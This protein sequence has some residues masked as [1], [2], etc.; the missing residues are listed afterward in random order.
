MGLRDLFKPKWEHSDAKVRAAAVATLEDTSTVAK[1]AQFDED[2]D[3]R[4]AAVGRLDDQPT[5]ETVATSDAERSVRIAAL[6]RVRSQETLERIATSDPNVAVREA[7]MKLVDDKTKVGL[8][9]SGTDSRTR[10]E[11]VMAIGDAD[12]LVEVI[13][14]STHGDVRKP[15]VG[16]L[17]TFEQLMRVVEETDDEKVAQ[18]VATRFFQHSEHPIDP[19]QEKLAG[20]LKRTE[21]PHPDF[22][23]LYL[24]DTDLLLD[25]VRNAKHERVRANALASLVGVNYTGRK[26]TFIGDEAAK[27]LILEVLRNEKA[28]RVRALAAESANDFLSEALIAH[29]AGTDSDEEARFGAFLYVKDSSIA[30]N[31]ATEGT[32]EDIRR[33][34]ALRAVDDP[35]ELR[36]AALQDSSW[37]VRREAAS[38][39]DDLQLLAEI[40]CTDSHDAVRSMAVQNL[41]KDGLLE[42]V[43]SAADEETRAYAQR[44]LDRLE[45]VGNV[46]KRSPTPSR[47]ASDGLCKTCGHTFDWKDLW[48]WSWSNETDPTNPNQ[49]I[50]F[51][52]VYC[53]SCGRALL[54]YQAGKDETWAPQPALKANTE[55]PHLGHLFGTSEKL[56]DVAL[57]H[58]SHFVFD[59][60]YR[61]PVDSLALLL[62]STRERPA[63]GERHAALVAALSTTSPDLTAFAP[64]TEEL[65]ML[66]RGGS[67]E[68]PRDSLAQLVAL[69]DAI[70]GT[71]DSSLWQS[72]NRL[73][74]TGSVSAVHSQ[75][76]PFVDATIGALR[77]IGAPSQALDEL[78]EY[79]TDTNRD[80][81]QRLYALC[82]LAGLGDNR[83]RGPC[84]AWKSKGPVPWVQA[85]LARA[86][87]DLR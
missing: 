28:S 13:L 6:E 67:P 38:R 2:R 66:V 9:T 65:R 57:E 32:H 36:A 17:T 34:A 11:A 80:W 3:V 12:N 29:I 56:R 59:N 46:P 25:L 27:D 76:Q 10:L 86:L 62:E 39:V 50:D 75:S 70:G 20:F 44:R 79:G 68:A 37:G 71:G 5:L 18:A 8:A 60:R 64:T 41:Q 63:P 81:V 54:R 47:S 4:L 82:C 21:A 1:L 30:A 42:V 61:L 31:L 52:G 87:K 40:A 23:A 58:P 77:A 15:A 85:L 72:V 48:S 49:V 74:I 22:V 43:A 51:Q 73:V 26:E 19:D 53:P 55:L 16:R 78:A 83:A 14:K 84:V 7:A 45:K 69:L 33:A 24:V 35:D